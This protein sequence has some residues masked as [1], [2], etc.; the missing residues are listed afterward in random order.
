MIRPSAFAYNP[1]TAESNVF[2]KKS[3]LS[4]RQLQQKALLEFQDMIEQLKTAGIDLYI[5]DDPYNNSDSIFPNNWVSFHEDGTVVLYPM[6]AV[7][8][9]QERRIDILESLRTKMKITRIIDL[10]DYENK[11]IFLEGTGSIV[12]DHNNKKAYAALS[13]RTD[14]NLFL[15]LCNTLEYKPVTFNSTD[16]NEIPLYHTNVMMTVA[17]NFVL[18]CS[19]SIKDAVQRTEILA[20]LA[21]P[22]R[23]IIELT[24][25]QMEQFAGNALFLSGKNDTP[26]LL[27][28]KA[29]L[30][31]LR[32][33]QKATINEHC[34][35]LSPEIE[36]IENTGGGSVRCMVA[37]IFL[38][39]H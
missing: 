23:N 32:Q 17:H 27:M 1:E 30:R 14:K 37:E 24:F 22:G 19:D 21:S 16:R 2:Q 4:N 33:D 13:P 18:F 36:T 26:F 8:R 20:E 34:E 39:T 10:T 5:F 3:T 25:V 11:E 12:F 29:A 31:S 6:L 38:P 9:R 35:I 7:N 28:S 15:S